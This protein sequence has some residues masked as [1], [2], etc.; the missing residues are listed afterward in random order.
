MTPTNSVPIESA[1]PLA[2]SRREAIQR[3][4][5]ML[6]V[7]ITPSILTGVLRAQPAAVGSAVKPAHL[8]PPQFA[9]VTAAAERIL[10]RTDTPGATDVGVPA[11]IDLMVGKFM[12][13]FPMR[14]RKCF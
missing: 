6:G 7:A 11:F 14:H 1:D 13:S 8:T 12:T 5:L 10:P 4:A 9:I 2:M 3:V